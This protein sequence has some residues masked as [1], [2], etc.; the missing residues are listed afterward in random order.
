MAS[1]VETGHEGRAIA[2]ARP[3]PWPHHGSFDP[4]TCAL[5]ACLDPQWHRSTTRSHAADERLATLARATH[6]AGGLVVTVTSVP[7]RA[8]IRS[9]W[10]S[11]AVTTVGTYDVSPHVTLGA[12][13]TNAFF[14]SG[15]DEA[16]RAGSRRDVIIAG[17]GLEG[18]VHSTLRAANDRGYECL[19]VIDACTSLDEDLVD[20]ASRT[21]EYSGGIFGAVSTT[22]ELLRLLQR[23]TT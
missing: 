22:D 15:L 14:A 20:A 6:L 10:A 17:W 12:R 13:G 11:E 21:V 18:P 2:S 7:P 9:R 5:V 8:V 1:P 16:L 3:Y 23:T 4:A 19:L